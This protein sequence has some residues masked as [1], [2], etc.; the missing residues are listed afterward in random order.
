MF[1]LT[2]RRSVIGAVEVDYRPGR[3]TIF[4]AEQ[5]EL[6]LKYLA[7]MSN[8]GSGL[9]KEYLMALA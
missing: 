2:L 8:M 5:E 4:T 6:L 9:I 3:Q 7:T 1:H